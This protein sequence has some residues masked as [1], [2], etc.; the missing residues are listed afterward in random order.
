MVPVGH[1]VGYG[2][3]VVLAEKVDGSD[4]KNVED[5]EQQC[6]DI[7][8]RV[9]SLEHRI[10]DHLDPAGKK[11]IRLQEVPKKMDR[12]LAQGG[13]LVMAR[14]VMVYIVVREIAAGWLP[15]YGPYS[16]MA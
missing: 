7:E 12:E 5:Q 13:Y 10:Q 16:Y 8:N 6:H 11:N 9:H 14:I 4:C 15:R 2:Y 1:G 3:R